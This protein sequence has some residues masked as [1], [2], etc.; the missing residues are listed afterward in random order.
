MFIEILSNIIN[1]AMLF[2]ISVDILA[3]HWLRPS[4]DR[5][6]LT[7]ELNFRNIRPSLRDLISM[8]NLLSRR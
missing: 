1:I 6:G 8:K 5:S 4:K 3:V 2:Q 7:D